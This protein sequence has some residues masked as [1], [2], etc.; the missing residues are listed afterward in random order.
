MGWKTLTPTRRAGLLFAGVGVSLAVGAVALATIPDSNGAIHGCYVKSGGTL[1][2]IDDA[3]TPCKSGETSLNW[4]TA[5][6]PGP[7]GLSGLETVVAVNP[8]LAGQQGVAQA[9]CPSGKKPLGGGFNTF[10]G[11]EVFVSEP[12]VGSGLPGWEA[13]AFNHNG[14]DSQMA[15]YAICA[16]VAS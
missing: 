8:I 9:R 14:E 15:V 7:P 2:V 10:S 6:P 1:R 11:V 13:I 5:G 3:V 12:I 16:N 4:N